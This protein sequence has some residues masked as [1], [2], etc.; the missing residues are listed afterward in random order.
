LKLAHPGGPVC[1]LLGAAK[2]LL[3][4][5]GTDPSI[6]GT[7]VDGH[8]GEPLAHAVISLSDIDRL[9]V[10]DARGHYEFSAVPPGP[11][12]ITVRR[13][14]YGPRTLHA[15]VPREGPV[16]INIALRPEP[17]RLPGIEVHS[18]VAVRGVETEDSTAYPDRGLSM[19]AVRNHPL[20]S[21][22]DPFVALDG[23]EIAV[24]PESPSGIHV[25]GGASDQTGYLLDGVPI[26]SPY[27]AA[28]LFSAWNPDALE[29]LQLASTTPSPAF[30][31]ALSGTVTGMTRT[32][33]SRLSAQG[34]F[35]TTQARLTLDGPIAAGA[36]YL[37]S[38]R[39][40]LPDLTAPQGDASYLRGESGDLL[41]KLELRAFGGRVRLLGYDSSNEISATASPD[42]VR[43]AFEWH[44]RSVGAEWSRRFGKLGL[45]IQ[46]WHAGSDAEVGWDPLGEAIALTAARRDY[47]LVAELQ[48]STVNAATTAGLR[49]QDSHTSYHPASRAGEPALLLD[50]RSPTVA[51]F[52][53][54]DQTL[55]RGLSAVVALSASAARALYFSPQVRIS[56]AP[57]RALVISGSYA[58]SHQFAQSL[59]NSESVVDNIFPADVFVGIGDSGVPVARSDLGV[60][61]AE[62]R[63]VTGVRV[64]GQVYLRD[65]D[66]LLLVAPQTGEPFATRSFATGSGIARGFSLDAGVSGSRFGLVASYGWQHL[67]L[68]DGRAR[69]VPNYGAVQTLEAGVIVFPSATSSI[70]L[71]ATGARGRRGTLLDSNVE[72]EACNLLDQGCE[73][74]GT[75]RYRTDQLGATSLPTYFRLDLGLRKHWHFDVGGRDVQLAVFGTLTNLLGR[76]NVLTL[77]PAEPGGTPAVIEMRPRGPLVVGLDWRF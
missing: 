15:L 75:P 36:G 49:A 64:S 5:Q 53:Q 8:T 65:L 17:M 48:R 50:A 41:A 54:H 29:H 25:R 12:H 11:Q 35:S 3:L 67:R 44:S 63:P 40:G 52:V 2:L 71:G 28:G 45:R 39:S 6:L 42:S 18:T 68:G 30:P 74:A 22:P 13:I 1:W 62:Y 76:K 27:H 16:E 70:R 33:G 61:A 69:Y 10:S 24:M 72:W 20:L 32:P 66:G 59:R 31:E 7:I 9:V 34:S 56:W 57:A 14:G 55:G 51:G 46:G 43:N 4:V 77:A 58:R 73:F 60:L 23:G 37:L 21:E 38:V 26:F 19:E 47:G